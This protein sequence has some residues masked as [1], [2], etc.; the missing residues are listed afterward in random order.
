MK[1]TLTKI[2][3]ARRQLREAIKLWFYDGDIAAIHSLSCSA[4]QI[5]YDI[6]RKN[7]GRD[8]IYD[9]IV[10]KDE[11]RKEW[12]R[13]IKSPYNFL[14]H[15]ENDSDPNGSIELDIEI[16]KFFILFTI[17]ALELLGY[18]LDEVEGAFSI[19]FMLKNPLLLK[20][21]KKNTVFQGITEEA[22]EAAARMPKRDFF[23]YYTIL[24]KRRLKT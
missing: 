23:D 20:E 4:H 12:I 16:T 15:A 19:Y 7:G 8:L 2:D 3:A 11:Y 10:I 9:S 21:E 1:I 13:K 14:K 18:K 5:V 22:K 24:R 6:N 17:L